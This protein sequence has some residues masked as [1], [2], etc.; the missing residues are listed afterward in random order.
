MKLLLIFIFTIFTYLNATN[1]GTIAT[2]S[3]TGGYY[4]LGT[5]IS[6][7]LKNYGLKLKPIVSGG[8]YQNMETLNGVY[9]KN[10]NTFFAIVQK[11]AIP[12]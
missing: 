8:S 9:V 5:D 2:G 7:L 4:K 1:L 10:N 3:K 11:D 6:M 12:Y